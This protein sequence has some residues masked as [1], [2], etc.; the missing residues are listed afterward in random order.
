MADENGDAT[1]SIEVETYSAEQDVKTEAP[2]QSTEAKAETPAPEPEAKAEGEGEAKDTKPKNDD[3]PDWAK[4]RFG[5]L[6][7][8]RS[9]AD[10]R[11]QELEA[12]LAQYEQREQQQ[13]EAEGQPRQ[14][15]QP[16][17][18]PYVLAEH[19]ADTRAF[20]Q[21]CDDIYETGSKEFQDFDT[22]L[23]N[24]QL[25]GGLPRHLVEAA[26]ATGNP[27]KVLYELGKNPAEAERLMNLPPVRLGVE[28]AKRAAAAPAAKPISKAPAPIS[29]VDGAART[30]DGLTDE[31]DDATWFARRNAQLSGRR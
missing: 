10:R 25:L 21:R 5:E 19:I 27:A 26:D 29:P 6:T 28:M 16:P 11:A 13:P 1:Q 18:D 24:F 14:P 12:R 30:S 23:G 9:E 22:A 20:N 4:K 8:Q 31:L 17:V 7:R 2:D 3:V 15:Q